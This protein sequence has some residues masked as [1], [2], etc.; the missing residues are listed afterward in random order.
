MDT[1][2][3][4][5]GQIW[6]KTL[7]ELEMLISKANF[8]TWLKNTN[9]EKTENGIVFI[10]VPNSFSKE[11][12]KNKYNKF[13]ISALRKIDP[14]I[15]DTEYIV[16]NKIKPICE[17][18]STI[19]LMPQKTEESQQMEFKEFHET[20]ESLNPRYTFNDFIVGSFNELAHAAAV[21][22][23]KNP[24]T[25][26][27][28]L[29]IYGGVGLGKTHLLQAI[30]NKIKEDNEKSQ[31]KYTTLEKFANMLISSIQN[32]TIH[33]FKEGYKKYDLLIIDDIQFLSGK[34]KT[35]E[36][37]FHIFNSLYEKNKQI[38]FSSDRSPKS[39][40]DLEERL[41]SRFE[42]GMMADISEPEYEARIAILKSKLQTKDIDLSEET[43][44]YIASTIKNNV[45]ELEGALNL[46]L[47]QSKLLGKNLSTQELK[48]I[49][50]KNIIYSKKKIT[51]NKIIKTIGDF[52]EIEERFIFEK[53]RR[54]E[55]VLPRQIIMYL[56]REDFN[57][58]Y[59]YIGKKLGGRDH[60][61]A[62]HAYEKISKDIKNNYQIK[63]EIQKIRDCLYK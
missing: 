61:T 9:I 32:N 2:Q 26:Y 28:P 53:S 43:I 45:R 54:K 41:R 4:E 10:G 5:K 46:L 38:I 29:F 55:Y 1:Q 17:K 62:I 19:K 8:V 7:N 59:P 3:T 50:N 14:S 48:E 52:Y 60:T 12:V 24:G 16:S 20:K 18:I 42:G 25:T 36:E 31:I 37:L 40:L 57:A 35:Q 56:L 47:A 27:N 13:I 33:E 49:F 44:N 15:K 23:I 63:D 30:G 6:E 21:A 51:F 58:S 11:W 22:V 39:I 34:T